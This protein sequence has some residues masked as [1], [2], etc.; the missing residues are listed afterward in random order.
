MRSFGEDI[1][2]SKTSTIF[3]TFEQFVDGLK[4]EDRKAFFYTNLKTAEG[5]YSTCR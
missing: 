1:A 2:P 3:S 5:E 4:E